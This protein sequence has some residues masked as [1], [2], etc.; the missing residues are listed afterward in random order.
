MAHGII[1][2]R[3]ALTTSVADDDKKNT[4]TTCGKCDKT[5][6]HENLGTTRIDAKTPLKHTSSTKPSTSC[7]CTR[8]ACT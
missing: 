2:W 3:E 1:R 5:P 4:K 7:D 8:A 6:A